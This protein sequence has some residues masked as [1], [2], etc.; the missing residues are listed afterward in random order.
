MHGIKVKKYNYTLSLTTA[1]DGGGWSTLYTWE[2]DPVPIL[3]ECGW[4]PELV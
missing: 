3:Q 2:R 1:L 4:A